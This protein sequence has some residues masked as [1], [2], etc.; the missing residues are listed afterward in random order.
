MPEKKRIPLFPLGVVLLPGLP[1]PLHIFEER[2]KQM[3]A[4]C[5]EREDVFGLV[6]YNG[7]EIKSAGCTARIIEVLKRYE[8]GRLDIMTVGERRFVISEK[9]ES[10]TYLQGWVEFFDDEEEELE[11]RDR[12]LALKGLILHNELARLLSA[13][14]PYDG[15][16]AM[17]LK[18]ISFVLAGSQGFSLDEKQAFLEMTSTRQRIRKAVPALEKLIERYKLTLEIKRIIGGNGHPPSVL[19]ERE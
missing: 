3:I 1:L 18:E 5:L 13:E 9:D 19:G 4:E 2:Y 8:D 15:S 7:T 11:D 10:K 16:G 14:A 17:E 12:E 6:A